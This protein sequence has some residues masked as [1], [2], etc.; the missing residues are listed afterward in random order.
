MAISI[1]VSDTV[2]IKVTGS[3]NNA[4]GTPVPFNFHLICTRLDAD[5]I[6]EKLKTESDASLIDFLADITTGWS[7]VKDADDTFL[8][9][10]ESN[11]RRL[12]KLPG[13][14]G[15]AFRTYLAEAGAKEKN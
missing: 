8:D 14:A 3:I 1:V 12:C 11:L 9:Y 4:S 10:S 13:I 6:Q 7:G 2:G 15:I 5:Q